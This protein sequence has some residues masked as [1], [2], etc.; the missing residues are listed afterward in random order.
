MVRRDFT[1]KDVQEVY[2]GVGG[3]LWELVM[4]EQI[5]SGGEKTTDILAQALELKPGMLVLDICSALGGPAR[6]LAKKY[7]V[8]VVGLDATPRMVEEA[9]K[10]TEA[11]GLSH[12][13]EYVLGNA[14]DL[15]FKQETFDVVWGQEAWCYIT[16]KKRLINEAYRVL[17][18]GGKIGFTDWIITGEPSPAELQ[19]LL[20]SMT[21]PYMETFEGYQKLLKEAGFEILIA[22]DETEDFHNYFI[23]YQKKVHGELKD[24][25]LNDFGKDIFD[26]ASYLVNLWEKASREHKVGRGFYVAIKK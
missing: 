10:R 7:G 5:H 13:V 18:K 17:K 12:L 16:D 9:I 19:E 24:I 8:K 15:P 4:G 26:F 21:F 11:A 20:D 2:Q 22:R 25:I 14:L 3:K 1:I 23:E 6:H